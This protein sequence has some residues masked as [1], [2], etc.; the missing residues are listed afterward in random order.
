MDIQM[1]IM[2]GLVATKTIQR[3]L[4]K[5]VTIVGLS[6]HAFQED[7]EKAKN[8]GMDA[9]LTKPI[10]I[11]ELAQVIRRFADKKQKTKKEA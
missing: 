3:D 10:Q 11:Q 6:A 8:A 1:P 2:D 4:G 5:D 9:Y 7:V